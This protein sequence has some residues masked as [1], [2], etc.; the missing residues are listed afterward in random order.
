MSLHRSG[1]CPW[2]DRPLGSHQAC[3][4]SERSR[5]CENRVDTEGGVLYSTNATGG[6]HDARPA[7]AHHPLTLPVLLGATRSFWVS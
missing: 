2:R 6:L 5:R 7:D 3:G 1:P 4:P